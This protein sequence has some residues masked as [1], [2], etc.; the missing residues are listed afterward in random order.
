MLKKAKLQALSEET[1]QETEDDTLQTAK[2]TEEKP[3]GRRSIADI[4]AATSNPEE[5]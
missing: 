5:E 1:V 4:I 3:A 2:D